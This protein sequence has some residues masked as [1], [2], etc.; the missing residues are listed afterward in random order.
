MLDNTYSLVLKLKHEPHMY[1]TIRINTLPS[2][3]HIVYQLTTE[4]YK[5]STVDYIEEEV[6]DLR[7]K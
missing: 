4:I 5:Y 7:D 1:D 3:Y 2:V 6:K